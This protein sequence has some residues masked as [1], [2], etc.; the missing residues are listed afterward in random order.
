MRRLARLFKRLLQ[1]ALIAVL[2]L[3]LPVGYVEFACRPSAG[4]DTYAPL[5]PPDA[6]RPEARTLLTYPEWHIVHAYD[7][8]ARVISEED[9]HAFGFFRAIGQYWSSLCTLS[10]ETAAMGGIDGET[11][12]MV[13]VIGVSFTVEM[14]LKAA[15]EET[16]GRLFAALREEERAPLDTLSAEQAAQYAAFLQQTPWYKWNF[17]RDIAALEAARTNSLR[18]NERRFALGAEYSVKAAYAGAIADA[19]AAT[20]PDELTLR[21]IVTGATAEDLASLSG[22][23][24]IAPR[25]EGIEIET[26]RYRALTLLMDDLAAKGVDFV[27]IAGNDDIMLTVLSPDPQLTGALMS[28]PRQGYG[29][30]RHLLL[31]KVT[32]LA[33]I[34]RTIESGPVRLE[35]VHDY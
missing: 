30:T 3:A 11:R 14:A 12:R 22:V 9:P 2:L 6:R 7:D 4:N 1:I 33:E 21:M 13:Y 25:D 24:V 10:N 34:L 20:G 32:N 19:V 15:Y 23:S 5:L 27:E 26:I 35:H 18:D 29:D 31:V 16:I 17:R 8:Y 28:L